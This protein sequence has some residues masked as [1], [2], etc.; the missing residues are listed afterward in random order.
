MKS[1]PLHM[2][3]Y[4]QIRELITPYPYSKTFSLQQ[5]FPLK[6]I[7]IPPP[8]QKNKQFLW[9]TSVESSQISF[10]SV[11]YSII[12]TCI[13]NEFYV[14]VNP[15]YII[16]FY[17]ETLPPPQKATQMEADFCLAPIQPFIK[18]SIND[19]IHKKQ[20][21]TTTNCQKLLR[22]DYLCRPQPFLGV[23]DKNSPVFVLLLAIHSNF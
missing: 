8:P 13:F 14:R 2:K 22:Q 10:D 5:R 20:R 4:S 16:T 3:L 6:S 21:I 12:R 18:I 19:F 17:Q 9:V 11:Q 15:I 1:P 23:T 7:F